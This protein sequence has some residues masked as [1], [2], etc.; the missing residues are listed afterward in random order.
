[1]RTYT[2]RTGSI[3]TTILSI[4]DALVEDF[5]VIPDLDPVDKVSCHA[6]CRA[7]AMRHEEAVCVDGWFGG[8]GHD[9]SWLDLGKGI[10]ADIYPIAGSAPF[11][12]DA[13]HFMVPWHRLYIPHPTLLDEGGRNRKHHEQ[14]AAEICALLD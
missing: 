6:V 8:V 10:I 4:F 2:V 5:K 14:V 3:P 7:L 12:V 1:M 13:S 11:L 9:H